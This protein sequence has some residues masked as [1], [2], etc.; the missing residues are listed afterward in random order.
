MAIS[1]KFGLAIPGEARPRP[2]V[3]ARQPSAGDT[4]VEVVL[5]RGLVGPLRRNGR[6]DFATATGGELVSSAI[7]QVLG[8]QCSTP[9]TH[10]EIPWRPDFG[11]ALARLRYRNNDEVLRALA[12]ELVANALIRWEPRV[13]VT[14]TRVTSD[15]TTLSIDLRYAIVSARRT[16][17]ADGQ[18]TLQLEVST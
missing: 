13:R 2:V 12:E 16:P 15:G 18:S 7:G 9:T 17:L 10:G 4:T 8:T 3:G 14:S 6:G 5:G 11:S 1:L